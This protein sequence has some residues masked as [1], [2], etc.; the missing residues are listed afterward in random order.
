M[1]I[2]K[3]ANCIRNAINF[4]KQNVYHKFDKSS[5]RL[6]KFKE[7]I[8]TISPK[9]VKLLEFKKAEVFTNDPFYTHSKNWT[10]LSELITLC[11][12][13]IVAVEHDEYKDLDKIYNLNIFV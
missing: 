7:D 4:S 8:S 6:D 3:D 1:L 2:S 5:F 12:I 10:A 11:D 13:I 9:L